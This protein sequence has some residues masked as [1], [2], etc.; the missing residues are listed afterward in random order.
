MLVNLNKFATDSIFPSKVIILQLD[1]ETLKNRLSQ[2]EHDNIEKRGIDYLLR[3]Q[4]NIIN[5]CKR[6]EIPYIIIDASKSI[7]EINFRIK[8]ALGV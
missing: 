7:E 6:L 1:K 2:K 4:E 5:T 3:I 8:R